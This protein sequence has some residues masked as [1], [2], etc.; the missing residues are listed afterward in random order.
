MTS[1]RPT[2]DRR[3]AARRRHAVLI[4]VAVLVLALIIVPP[5]LAAAGGGSSGFGRGGGGGEG[6]K[7][8]A[9]YILFQLLFRIALLGHGLGALFLLG[10]AILYVLLTRV[11]PG[12]RHFWS[13]RESQ[14]PAARRGSAQRQRRVE[15]AAAEAAEDDPAFAPDRVRQEVGSLFLQIQKAWDAGDRA[16]L[17]RLVGRDL[18]QEWE[19]RLDDFARKGWRNRVEPVEAPRIEYVGLTHRGDPAGDRVTVRIEAKL[20]D[21][22]VDGSGR[23][24]K[25]VGRVTDTVRVREF[26]T[27][28][29]RFNRWILVSIEQGAEGAHGLTDQ[30]VATPWSDDQRLRDEALVEQAVADALPDEVKPSEVADLQFTG[31]ARAA[32]L[33]L[34]LADG[35]FAPA[36]LE[37]AAR[38][39]VAAWADAVD[40]DDSALKS[41]A[42]REAIEQLLHPGDPDHR[43]RL[44]IRGPRVKQIRIT[45]LQAAAVPPLMII[46][47]EIEGPRYVEDRATAALLSG[48][49]GRATTFTEHWTL[50]LSGDETQPWRITRAASPVLGA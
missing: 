33:D 50:A 34:S 35:R 1:R 21:Y 28:A 27:L 46:D 13:A 26:W 9:I 19:R 23:H 18:L 36:V 32:A 47:V 7:G 20:R 11:M 2:G 39:A 42:D 22:V 30:I 24:I 4:F 44:V 48:S 5:A 16:T 49:R 17:A 15:L 37:V 3:R 43:T 14:G 38:R 41:I 10:V 8:F 6:G 29:R 45:G 12:S 25:R 40:G 31:D